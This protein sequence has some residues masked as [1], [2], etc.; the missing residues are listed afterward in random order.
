MIHEIGRELE[1]LLLAQGCGFKVVDREAFARTAWVSGVIV[2]DETGDTYG[3]PRSQSVNPKRHFDCAT[4][5]KLTVY[6]KSAKAGAAEFEHKRVA[7]RAVDLCL[8]ALRTIRAVRRIGLDIGAGG[9]VDIPDLAGSERKGGAVYEL[10]FTF[11]R[12]VEDRTWAG[13]AAAEAGS[14]A[15]EGISDTAN[16]T[17]VSQAFGPDDDNNPNT[18]PAS[19]ETACGA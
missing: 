4:G 6:G 17:L 11:T 12:A 10:A 15:G 8:V 7:R 1:A 14:A 13:S 16:E 19:A 5:A 2:I 9:F 3:P 18:P